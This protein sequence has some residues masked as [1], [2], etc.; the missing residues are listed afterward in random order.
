[1]GFA[2]V[3]LTGVGGFGIVGYH[4]LHEQSKNQNRNP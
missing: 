1:M 2:R 4:V 3:E